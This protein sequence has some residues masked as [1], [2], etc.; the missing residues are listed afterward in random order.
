MSPDDFAQFL[1]R[2]SPDADEAE[3][4]YVSLQKKL[5]GFLGMRD[6]SDP[7]RDAAETLDRA[8]VRISRGAN[9]P[10]VVNYCI[11]IARN[12]ASE[13][14]RRERRED[15]VFRRFIDSL[16][17][18][19]AEEVERI[20]HMLKPCFENLE[21]ESQELLVSYCRIPEGQSHAEHRRRLSEKMGITVRALRTQVSRLRDRLEDCVEG[22]SE[23]R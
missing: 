7:A 3:R 16:A 9:V 19:S 21:A 12:V 6:V 20:Q 18:G 23:N 4:R 2:L 13:S 11:G 8:A 1:K 15:T 5:I 22:R 14:W 10:D 17:D